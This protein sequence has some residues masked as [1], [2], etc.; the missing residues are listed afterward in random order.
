VQPD[1]PGIQDGL[2]L[3]LE[4][5]GARPVGRVVHSVGSDG[6]VTESERLPVGEGDDGVFGC[7][8]AVERVGCQKDPG[9]FTHEYRCA[10][11]Q[12]GHQAVMVGVA[13]GDEHRLG[14]LRPGPGLGPDL[15]LLLFGAVIEIQRK[16][17]I[18]QYFGLR[19]L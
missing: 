4:A 7:V 16:A 13:V 14:V 1:V 18:H 11:G 2:S 12:G 5:E 17:K 8:D 3:C 9:P 10:L 19:G 6:D 15:L